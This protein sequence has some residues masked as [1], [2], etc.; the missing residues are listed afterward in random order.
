M[1]LL[2]TLVFGQGIKVL[3]SSEVAHRI[4]PKSAGFYAL[5]HQATATDRKDGSKSRIIAIQPFDFTVV[6]Y[7]QVG[8]VP[9]RERLFWKYRVVK[10][11][12]VHEYSKVTSTL[13]LTDDCAIL[14]CGFKADFNKLQ[15]LLDKHPDDYAAWI[16]TNDSSK[17]ELLELKPRD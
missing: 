17:V 3:D 16:E 4:D 10:G 13:E 8:D 5:V 15:Q 11:K 7:P 6:Q 14:Y 12:S 9:P 1:F 2:L